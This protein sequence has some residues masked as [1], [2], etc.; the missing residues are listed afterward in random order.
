MVFQDNQKNNDGKN[1][2]IYFPKETSAALLDESSTGYLNQ[3]SDAHDDIDEN[4][5]CW[6]HLMRCF[7]WTVSKENRTIHLSGRTKPSSFP[8]NRLN[9]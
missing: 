2:G 1:K 7:G 3:E 6:Y 4:F 8:S 9:N 5:G